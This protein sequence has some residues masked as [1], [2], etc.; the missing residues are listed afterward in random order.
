MKWFRQANIGLLVTSWWG[1]NRL[2]DSNTTD[3]VMEHEDVGNLKIALHYETTSR[4]GDRREKL[5][6]AKADNKYMCENYFNHPNYYQIDGR[7]VLLIY[8][9]RKLYSVGTL[10]EA[11]LTMRSTASKCGHNLYLIG[12]TVFESAPDP[13]EPHVPFWYFDAV[14]NYDIYGRQDAQKVTLVPVASTTTIDSRPNEK[15]KPLE[16]SADIFH[17]FLPDTT[18]VASGWKVIILRSPVAL[19]PRHKKEASSISN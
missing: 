17:P 3:V 18:I 8:V 6:N 11:L 7:P 12:D 19:L 5:P 15:N 14:T 10:E 1:P 9:S 16:T 4:L 2:E 13:N